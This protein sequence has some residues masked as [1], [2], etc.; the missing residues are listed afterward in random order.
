[1]NRALSGQKKRA[2]TL[3]GVGEWKW[4]RKHTRKMPKIV[5][6][7]H[8]ILRKELRFQNSTKLISQAPVFS[9]SSP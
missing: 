8:F 1:V 9:T 2:V 5:D 6:A 4:G 3:P 7:N